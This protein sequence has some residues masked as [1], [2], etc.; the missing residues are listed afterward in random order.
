MER[1]AGGVGPSKVNYANMCQSMHVG[2]NNYEKLKSFE[3]N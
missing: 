3:F 2:I 1:S